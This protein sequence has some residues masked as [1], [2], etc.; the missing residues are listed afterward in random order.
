MYQIILEPE[1]KVK[2]LDAWNRRF[3][4]ALAPPP[5]FRLL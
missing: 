3:N 5:C 1:L 2:T 4:L